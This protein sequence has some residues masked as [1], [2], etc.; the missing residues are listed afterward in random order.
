MGMHVVVWNSRASSGHQAVNDLDRAE[1]ISR[2]LK[3]AI[4]EAQ[5]NVMSAWEYGAAAVAERQQRRA[6]RR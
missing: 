5:I 4:P 6:M 1:A 3:R 2:A